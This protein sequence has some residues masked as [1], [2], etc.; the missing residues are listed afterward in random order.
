[1]FP[2]LTYTRTSN[3]ISSIMH[4]FAGVMTT[5]G[6]SLSRVSTS[7]MLRHHQ[8]AERGITANYTKLYSIPYKL[9]NPAAG[10]FDQQ[11]HSTMH[12]VPSLCPRHAEPPAESSSSSD[13]DD[14]DDQDSA[15]GKAALNYGLAAP[16]SP[17]VPTQI[18]P[19]QQTTMAVRHQ[20]RLGF[21]PAQPPQQQQSQQAC[22]G[23]T[24]CPT[25]GCL[26]FSAAVGR[27]A[28]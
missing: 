23:R 6:S 14:D 18:T 25:V 3:C 7:M 2:S 17:W 4:G 1:M 19:Q 10:W 28:S 21:G 8:P 5:A 27:Q 9:Q 11:C 16:V 22:L 15:S 24:L 12:P 20:Y 26:W 13:D